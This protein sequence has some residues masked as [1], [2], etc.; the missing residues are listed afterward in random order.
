MIQVPEGYVLI[1]QEEYD[2]LIERNVT[3]NQKISGWFK[4]MAGAKP[5]AALR[6]ITDTAPKNG[7]TY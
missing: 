6:S 5:F 3:V 4:T 2:A 1:K 7:Q